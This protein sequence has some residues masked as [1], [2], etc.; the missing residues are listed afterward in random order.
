MEMSESLKVNAFGIAFFAALTAALIATTYVLTKAPIEEN[1]RQQKSAKLKEIIG[2]TKTDNDVFAQTIT[3]NGS[4]FG[5]R[6]PIKAHVATLKDQVVTIVFQC[7]LKRATLEILI[8]WSVSM[9]IPVLPV[10][11]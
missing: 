9:P 11:V 6:T 8:Y 1:I 5:Y 4:P 7:R 2:T 10:S 3:L